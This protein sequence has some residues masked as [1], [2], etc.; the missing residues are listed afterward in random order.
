[1]KNIIIGAVAGL[2][3]GILGTLGVTVL[4]ARKELGVDE[5]EL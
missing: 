2:I 4:K 3:T 5:N 1:M